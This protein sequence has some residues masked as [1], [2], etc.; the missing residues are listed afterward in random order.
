MNYVSQGVGIIDEY[1]IRCEGETFAY[2]FIDVDPENQI[3]TVIIEQSSQQPQQIKDYL[4]KHCLFFV[5]Q[6]NQAHLVGLI[7]QQNEIIK[8]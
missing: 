6:F 4:G 3:Q 2:D 5:N 8:I 1:G 7:G